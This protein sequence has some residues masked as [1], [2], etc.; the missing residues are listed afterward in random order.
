MPAARIASLHLYPAKSCRGIALERADVLGTGLACDGVRDREWMIVDARGHL[1]T[2]R[3]SPRM[4]GIAW[5]IVDGRAQMRVPG[6][7]WL[8]PARYGASRD[9]VVWRS[10]VRGHDAGDNAA[11]QLSAH[12]D[13]LVRLVRF[14]DSVPRL[15]NPEFAGDSGATTLFADGYPLLVIGSASL[16]DLN[17]RLGDRGAMPVPMNR[18]RPSL[19]VDGLDPYDEDHLETL[20]TGTVVIRPVKPC[21]R[22]IMT[23]TDQDTGARADEP[24]LTLSS[25]R[26]DAAFDGITFGMNAI[27]E[28]PPGATLR[29]GDALEATYR[30]D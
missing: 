28:A 1:V 16:D 6:H 12:L 24:L 14:D 2:Q 17:E 27:V 23:T 8:E 7:D 10:Q 15:C 4:T 22:C 13:Q 21:T 29:V 19:V 9:V 18:F 26:T 5:R 3:E 25:Y 30:F 20:S 11:A